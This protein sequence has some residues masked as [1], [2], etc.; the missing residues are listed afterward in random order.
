[1]GIFIQNSTAENH[2]RRPS[3][4]KINLWDQTGNITRDDRH[5]ST[6]LACLELKETAK[7]YFYVN[8]EPDLFDGVDCGREMES[9]YGGLT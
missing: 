4:T 6:D 7:T 3:R 5:C 9:I 8:T 1:M 2:V